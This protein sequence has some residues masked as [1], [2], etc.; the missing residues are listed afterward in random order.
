MNNPTKKWVKNLN[1]M[2]EDIVMAK[3]TSY[4]NSISLVI[5][6]MQTKTI[7]KC[8]YTSTKMVK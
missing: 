5:R 7:I 3:N 4:D 1:T 6:E 8:H 2:Q